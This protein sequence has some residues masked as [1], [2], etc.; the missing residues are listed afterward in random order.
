MDEIQGVMIEITAI[1]IGILV[2]NIITKVHV[3]ESHGDRWQWSKA[4]HDLIL[5]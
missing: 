5:D 1:I 4:R 2:K 3:R